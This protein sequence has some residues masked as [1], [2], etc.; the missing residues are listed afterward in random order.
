MPS[1]NETERKPRPEVFVIRRGIQEE[2]RDYYQRRCRPLFGSD[3]RVDREGNIFYPTWR[4]VKREEVEPGEYGLLSKKREKEETYLARSLVTKF[5]Y[6]LQIHQIREDGGSVE[7]GIRSVEHVLAT[8]L[9]REKPQMKKVRERIGELFGLF[10]NFSAV[11]DEQLEEA[12]KETY[13]RLTQVELNPQRVILEE[14]KRLAQWL[15]KASGGRDSL[16]RRNWLITMMALAAANRRAFERRLGIGETVSKFARMREALVFA[17]EFSR[18]ILGEVVYR[19]EPQRI[20]AHYLFKYPESPPQ[21]TGIV[22]GILRTM[23]WQL[24]QPPIKPYKPTGLIAG[25]ALE[26]VVNL[27][28]KN[29]RREIVERNL[30]GEVKET[31]EEVLVKY[32]EIY[33]EDATRDGSLR[34]R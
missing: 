8:E 26:E 15:V 13:R 18:E 20:P 23:R 11:T 22:T 10:A 6:E 21:N 12:E 29:R 28:E 1:T 19:L 2:L 31:L 9:K 34:S 4:Q 25:E 32:Q 7:A 5:L 17:R 3:I 33:P 16:E 24:T 30:F 14:K 27:L